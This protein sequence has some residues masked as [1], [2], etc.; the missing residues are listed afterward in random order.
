M[1]FIDREVRHSLAKMDMT[2]SGSLVWKHKRLFNLHP[3]QRP[4]LGVAFVSSVEWWA[5]IASEPDIRKPTDLRCLSIVRSNHC[6]QS[7]WLGRSFEQLNCP[8]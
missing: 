1:C 8:G 7:K 2:M 4:P 6:S 3:K 5:L